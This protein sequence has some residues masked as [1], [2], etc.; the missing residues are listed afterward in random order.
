[1]LNN[2]SPR[3][4]VEKC[5]YVSAFGWGSGGADA[6]KKLGLPGGGPKYCLTPLC[7]FEFADPTKR[8]RVKSIHPGVTP[9]MVMRQTGFDPGIT[10]SAPTTAAPSE[11][12]L[13]I[14][15][16]RVDLAGR[17]RK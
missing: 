8:M 5:D 6:R 2:H 4:L 7:V 1:M 12:E 3:V 13:H 16:T 15:R 14:L 9:E 10:D 17:L 11:E